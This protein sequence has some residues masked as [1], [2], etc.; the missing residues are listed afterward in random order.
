MATFLLWGGGSWFFPDMFFEG[1]PN[2]SINVTEG[3]RLGRGEKKACRGWFGAEREERAWHPFTFL[4]I[5]C[6]SNILLWREALKCVLRILWPCPLNEK[7]LQFSSFQGLT[8]VG[9]WAR[10][11]QHLCVKLNCMIVKR[12]LIRKSLNDPSDC[13]ALI[14]NHLLFGQNHD[15]NPWFI[16]TKKTCTTIRGGERF[17]ISPQ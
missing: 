6:S 16:S 1:R 2:I 14:P 8:R 12:R 13:R 17:D 10:D 9:W 3:K 7:T 11:Y 15:F 4:S 5:L